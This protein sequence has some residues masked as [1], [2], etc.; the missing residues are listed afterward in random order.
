MTDEGLHAITQIYMEIR[1]L[2]DAVDIAVQILSAESGTEAEPSC[3]VPITWDLSYFKGKKPLAVVLPGG[4]VVET[5][6]WKQVAQVLL[7]ECAASPE[8]KERL[9]DMR[10]KVLGRDRTLLADT[11]KGM[12]SPIKFAD[13]FYFESKFDTETLLR[14]IVERIYL[15]ARFNPKGIKIRIKL[16]GLKPTKESEV[17]HEQLSEQ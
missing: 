4:N 3:D 8:A 9:L 14:V 1:R 12:D 6:K 5:T 10:G 16:D 13:G 11:P 7:A 15:P 2:L 17:Q